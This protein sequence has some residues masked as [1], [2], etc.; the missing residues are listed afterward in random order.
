SASVFWKRK[1][2]PPTGRR[3]S[4]W[5]ERGSIPPSPKRARQPSGKLLRCLLRPR[6]RQF[7]QAVIRRISGCTRRSEESYESVA[8]DRAAAAAR[9]VASSFLSSPLVD[10]DRRRAVRLHH[11]H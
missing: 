1:K 4:L 11:Q 5:S 3:C 8:T 7:T 9:L 2:D 6:H 10:G